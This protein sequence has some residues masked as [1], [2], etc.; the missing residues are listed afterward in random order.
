M[1][2]KQYTSIGKLARRGANLPI[3]PS[4]A[5]MRS[6]YHTG[7]NM[8]P[9]MG[10]SFRQ[11]SRRNSA[12]RSNPV[13]RINA[14]ST[15]GPTTSG[16][17]NLLHKNKLRKVIGVKK[18]LVNQMQGMVRNPGPEKQ[19]GPYKI[20]GKTRLF[21]SSSS[22]QGQSPG[23]IARRWMSSEQQVQRK[24]LRYEEDD[25][26]EF[27]E[28]DLNMEDSSHR[29]PA[30]LSAT[31]RRFQMSHYNR[32]PA[33]KAAQDISRSI[34]DELMVVD[35]DVR[36]MLNCDPTKNNVREFNDQPR[37]TKGDPLRGWNRPGNLKHLSD[38]AVIGDQE[39]EN[40]KPKISPRTLPDDQESRLTKPRRRRQ[41]VVGR[42]TTNQFAPEATGV[43]RNKDTKNPK[44]SVPMNQ[45]MALAQLGGIYSDR[46]RP[47]PQNNKISDWRNEARPTMNKQEPKPQQI[48]DEFVL[49]DVALARSVKPDITGARGINQPE[50]EEQTPP[51][52]PPIASNVSSLRYDQP[53]AE[54][55][56]LERI[57]FN[58]SR[59]ERGGNPRLDELHYE[60]SID[61]DLI[62]RSGLISAS[63]HVINKKFAGYRQSLSG[64]RDAVKYNRASRQVVDPVDPIPQLYSKAVIEMRDSLPA[65]L[66]RDAAPRR[67]EVARIATPT[68][69]GRFRRFERT[70]KE[71]EKTEK[72]EKESD[73]D[74]RLLRAT[75]S[76]MPPPRGSK[77]VSKKTSWE[78]VPREQLARTKPVISPKITVG[79][80]RDAKRSE[81]FPT[82]P[83]EDDIKMPKNYS[84]ESA[85]QRLG[86]PYSRSHRANNSY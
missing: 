12:A 8:G 85:V 83:Q 19:V 23:P 50:V 80:R 27:E 63:Q 34:Q 31:Q 54:K 45:N 55:D 58:G 30:S 42:V 66:K 26:E 16:S 2:G 38:I 68:F 47:I 48:D 81:V 61:L 59:N 69:T 62:Q 86:K 70:Q 4:G 79:E 21:S 76:Y 49:M 7:S 71:P 6:L 72:S 53:K 20:Y 65:A 40:P 82:D 46:N 60:P 22:L 77:K 33:L 73:K 14:S 5:T 9:N 35:S 28:A 25:D 37:S 52:P 3:L 64:N 43:A 56:F 67:T 13:Q 41:M 29:Y 1:N 10:Q 24:Q 15:S 17:T 78:S 32:G 84:K 74:P 11:A 18:T 57:I 36:D 44:T 39:K 51:P 75:K